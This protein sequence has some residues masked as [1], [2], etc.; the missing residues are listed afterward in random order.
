[1]RIKEQLSSDVLTIGFARC[2]ATYKRP[3]CYLPICSALMS[4]VNNK[5]R[6]VQFLFAGKAHPHDGAGQDLIKRIFEVSQRFRSSRKILFLP[7]YDM[8]SAGCLVQG[9]DVWLNTPT[10]CEASGTS[11]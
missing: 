9:V 10:L 8:Q 1:M 7:N 2:F 4:I 3:T 11:G 6:P 5:E